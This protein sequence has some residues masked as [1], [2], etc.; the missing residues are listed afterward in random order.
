[1]KCFF[2]HDW[3][4]RRNNISKCLDTGQTTE[5]YSERFCNKCGK[6]QD[7]T[8]RWYDSEYR[9]GAYAENNWETIGYLKKKTHN[10]QNGKSEDKI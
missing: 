3:I 2:G 9:N 4:Y 10:V 5:R 1:M 8:V 7:N 6:L